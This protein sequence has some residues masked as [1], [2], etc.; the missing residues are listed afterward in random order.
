MRAGC[1][2]AGSTS[3]NSEDEVVVGCGG[4]SIMVMSPAAGQSRCQYG[5]VGALCEKGMETEWIRPASIRW[6]VKRHGSGE[7]KLAVWSITV[8]VRYRTA[9]QWRLA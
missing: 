9:D 5:A 6:L 3:G 2:G 1:S 7:L 4:G 8:Q